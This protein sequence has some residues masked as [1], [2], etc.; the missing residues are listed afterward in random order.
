MNRRHL[1]KTTL[2]T[3]SVLINRE[4]HFIFH[5]SLNRLSWTG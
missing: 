5:M 2:E 4:Q 1:K 3:K